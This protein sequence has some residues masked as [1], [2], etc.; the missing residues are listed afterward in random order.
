MQ[1]I[2][3][4]F[5][6]RAGASL[7]V[8][9]APLLGG[10]TTTGLLLTA[11]G[12]ATDTSMTWEIVKHVHAK[13]IE[14]GDMP[15]HRLDSVERALNVRCGAFVPGSIGVAD[16]QGSKLQGCALTVAV[17]DPRF[18]QRCRSS[19]RKARRP[20]VARVRR[21]SSSRNRQRSPGKPA[22]ISRPPRPRCSNR[23]AGWPMPTPVRSTTT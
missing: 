6:R 9:V 12:V 4:G 19:S 14:G 11:A 20:K 18:C 13:M 5:F 15:C 3:S 16:L 10:C 21:W 8:V 2:R 7:L 1:A 22:P 17:R 23:C